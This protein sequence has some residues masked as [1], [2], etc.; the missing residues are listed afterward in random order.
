VA[1]LSVEWKQGRGEADYS[2]CAGLALD[3]LIGSA[4]MYLVTVDLKRELL[5]LAFVDHVTVEEARACRDEVGGLLP[6]LK[7]GFRLLTDLSGLMEM[8]VGCAEPIRATMDALRG[9]GVSQI[10]RVIP[11]KKKDIG[12][13]V[14][15]Y[16]HYG[17]DVSFQ[18]VES[19]AEALRLI[20]S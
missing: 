14:M 11:D 5:H 18:T 4:F 20:R 6:T 15:S 17:P 2:R 1:C 16:F 13:T 8:E 12:F 10:I 19:L 7:T 9:R 3:S